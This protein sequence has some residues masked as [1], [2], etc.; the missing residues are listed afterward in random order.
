MDH[1][2][3]LQEESAGGGKMKE[4]GRR[5]GKLQWDATGSGF[6]LSG[7]YRM[8]FDLNGTMFMRSLGFVLEFH[9]TTFRMYHY[10]FNDSGELLQNNGGKVMVVSSSSVTLIHFDPLKIWGVS[11]F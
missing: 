11:P 8:A 7:G 10:M 9:G 5:I 6:T 1:I 4:V 3:L 2:I